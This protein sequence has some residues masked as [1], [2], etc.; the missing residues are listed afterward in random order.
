MKVA[1]IGAGNVGA[2][3][4]QRIAEADLADVVLLDVV[5]G[6]AEAKALDL[7]SASSIIRHSRSITGTTDYQGIAEADIVVVTAGS[8]RQ[9]G[10][11][12][13]DL[14]LDNA[15]TIKDISKNLVE[16]C[17]DSIVIVVTNPLDAMTYLTLKTTGFAADRVIGMGGVS[18][19]ARFNMLV[20]AELNTA[21]QHIQSVIIGAHAN[22]MVILPRLS[23]V[24]GSSISELLPQDRIEKLI[25]ETRNFGARIVK[26]L[27]KGSAYYGP[28]AGIF[29]LVDSIVKD[30]KSILCA[31]VYLGGPYGLR[32]LCIGVPVKVGRLGIEEIIEL[33]LEEKEK[34]DF[35]DSAE[36]VKKLIKELGV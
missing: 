15:K 6:K 29:S 27:G 16:Y 11:N 25:E 2:T 12:R 21:S 28:S 31:S 36:S 13:A 3:S 8:A 17:P 32:D 34:N 1:I 30:S 19:S 5:Q 9:P 22:N 4:A 33:K 7:S 20:A 35:L 18:D 10:Q 26:L 23:T 24:L 14:L